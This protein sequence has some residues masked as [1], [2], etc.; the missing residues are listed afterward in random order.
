MEAMMR[1][2]GFQKTILLSTPKQT[3]LASIQKGLH[4][5]KRL[6]LSPMDT[7]VIY[8]S[9]HGTVIGDMKKSQRYI[10]ASDTDGEDIAKTGLSIRWLRLYLKT[11]LSQRKAL[12]LATCYTGKIQSKSRYPRGQKGVPLAVSAP[13]STTM[14]ILNA[15]SY[16]YSA[17]ES[18][19]LKSDIYTHFLLLCIQQLAQ[20]A[21]HPK[22]VSALQ[23]HSCS[24]QKT[25]T[26]VLKH[27][28]VRQ[29]PGLEA[30]VTG[31]QAVYLYGSPPKQIQS[32]QKSKVS[33]TFLS[34]G[35]HPILQIPRDLSEQYQIHVFRKQAPHRRIRIVHF[36]HPGDL[37][38][39]LEQ[40]EYEVELFQRNTGKKR[41]TRLTLAQGEKRMLEP[42]P[43]PLFQQL[44]LSAGIAGGGVPLLSTTS[45][46]F[47]LLYRQRFWGFGLV[48]DGPGKPHGTDFSLT[49]LGLRGDLGWS[50]SLHP[51]LSLWTGTF[52]LSGA[53]IRI[54]QN[55]EWLSAFFFQFGATVSLQWRI[56]QGF[57]LS[58]S[59]DIGGDYLPNRQEQFPLSFYWRA[60]G[61]A[62][63]IF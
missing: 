62:F 55:Q 49:R 29:L 17:Y 34:K 24:V 13:Y 1:Q 44:S 58:L 11:F 4:E 8:V 60:Y 10:I 9:A 40:G 7:V 30:N 5:L 47:Q 46:S 57:G 22:A 50:F 31:L 36:P 12:I 18:K 26:Y 15:A 42:P 52:L 43:T 3:T 41:V 19:K 39:S 38:T 54:S 21:P 32:P 23:A 48:W 25:Y 59:G 27:R 37:V 6:N 51:R 14:L 56:Y 28:K 63:L 61:S 16:Q 35:N 20:K 45:P 2:G 33:T 53:V